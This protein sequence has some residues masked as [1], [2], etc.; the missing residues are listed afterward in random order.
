MEGA[1][2]SSTISYSQSQKSMCSSLTAKSS[3][4]SD[5]IKYWQTNPFNTTKA[6]HKSY[7]DF[8]P[9]DTDYVPN[10]NIF[11]TADGAKRRVN[12]VRPVDKPP[13]WGNSRNAPLWTLGNDTHYGREKP[14]SGMYFNVK[15]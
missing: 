3:K 8:V 12:A 5:A 11:G 4:K 15:F 14:Q 13:V 7:K 2:I 6:L 9:A 10:D 1:K